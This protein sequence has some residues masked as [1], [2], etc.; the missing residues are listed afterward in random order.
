MLYPLL[1]DPP[2]G[3]AGSRGGNNRAVPISLPYRPECEALGF[4]FAFDVKKAAS[5]RLSFRSLEAPKET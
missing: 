2:R 4:D 3:L 5:R 1:R